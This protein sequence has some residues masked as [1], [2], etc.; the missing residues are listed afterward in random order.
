MIDRII[1]V[2]LIICS[3]MGFLL[4]CYSIYLIWDET[5][6]V[7]YYNSNIRYETDWTKY[8]SMVQKQKKIIMKKKL[9]LYA[10]MFIYKVKRLFGWI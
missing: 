6:K 10:Y 7:K 9:E 1:V 5:K 2:Y 8:D 4:L 3:S